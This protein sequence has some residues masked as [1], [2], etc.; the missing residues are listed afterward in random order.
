MVGAEDD[1]AV[2]RHV[3]ASDPRQAEVEVE[4]R[5]QHRARQPVDDRVHA[6]HARAAVEP[7]RAAPEAGSPVTSGVP[8][9]A[10]LVTVRPMSMATRTL[11]GALAGAAAAGVWAAQQPLD[12][13]V[14]GLP[15]DDTELLGRWLVP[16]GGGWQP[17]GIA[18]HLANGALFGAAY[19]NVAPSLPV[20]PVLR[21]PLAGL[22][23]HLA[24]WP[25][26]AVLPRVHPARPA[27]AVGLGPRVRAVDL[28]PR[29]VRARAGRAR[30]PAQP[31]GRGAGRRSTTHVAA[32]N[33]HGSAEHLVAPGPAALS[34]RVL[35]T[36]ASG[37]AGAHLA[38]ACSA[39]GDDV[40]AL[41]RAPR[42]VD[43]RDADATRARSPPPRPRSSST[44]RRW[45]TS[46]ARGG[47][48]AATLR[49]QR[50]DDLNVLEAVRARGARGAGRRGLLRRGLRPA[51]DAAGRRE[52]AAAARRTRTRSR[53]RRATCSPA[54]TPTRTG[55]GSRGRARSTT[56]GR[57]SRRSTRSPRS[58][59]RS[60]PGSRPATRP[61]ASSPATPT[62]AAT[63][64]TCATWC[65]PTGCWRRPATAAPSTSARGGPRRRASSS[66]GS[67]AATGAEIEHVVDPALVR[68]H[69]VMEVR[70]SAALLTT[71]PAGRPSSRSSGRW[72]TR[73]RGGAR[74]SARA[75]PA[76]RPTSDSGERRVV[77]PR[78][79][80]PPSAQRGSR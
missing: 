5:L 67:A 80:G 6:A 74:R 64:P 49:R 1:R 75:A 43:L 42:S 61:S 18:L 4:E 12:R 55:S 41:S 79:S 77:R 45:P 65:A 32:S 71:R 20:P 7:S 40:V 39:A 72:P 3:L 50:R 37:F 76:A 27:A 16:K 48:P 35:I 23:E 73:S 68:A 26:T 51:G 78:S 56:P 29:A 52:R 36:G 17:A 31:A 34:R 9:G 19:A 70:G 13:R 60:R 8:G 10:R 21:G 63:T 2:R 58:R 28:A 46:A 22:A 59:A 11:R 47:D 33:G 53:R 54:S 62:R 69:E 66:T 14:F 24:T 30:A 38:A 44:W 57:A 25:G 15:Y